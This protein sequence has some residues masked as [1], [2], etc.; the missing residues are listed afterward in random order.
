MSNLSLDSAGTTSALNKIRGFGDEFGAA[1]NVVMNEMRNLVAN[2]EWQDPAAIAFANSL[3]QE[4]TQVSS[5][6][7]KVEESSMSLQAAANKMA[8]A[9]SSSANSVPRA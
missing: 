2:P 4:Q 8:D 3:L 7:N 1:A 5:I 9:S 6:L